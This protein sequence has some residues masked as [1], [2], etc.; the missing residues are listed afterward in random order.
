MANETH[1]CEAM[2]SGIHIWKPQRKG[3]R[4]RLYLGRSACHIRFCPFCGQ[5]LKEGEE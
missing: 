5:E 4:W 3:G 1:R 2:P